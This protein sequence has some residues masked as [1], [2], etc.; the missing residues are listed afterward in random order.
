M[1]TRIVIPN[2]LPMYVAHP[3]WADRK[4]EVL[5]AAHWYLVPIIGWSVVGVTDKVLEEL[6][7]DDDDELGE[8]YPVTVQ[9]VASDP[10]AIAQRFPDG[11]WELRT[12]GYLRA[13]PAQLVDTGVLRCPGASDLYWNGGRR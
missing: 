5:I 9:G 10:Y 13:Y 2:T 12:R 8:T 3:H 6:H 4:A 7:P 11:S 1:S